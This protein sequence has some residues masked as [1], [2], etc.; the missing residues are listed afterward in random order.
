MKKTLLA[1]V[2]AAF[3]VSCTNTETDEPAAPAAAPDPQT[4]PYGVPGGNLP[5]YDPN[6]A[7]YQPIEPINPGAAPGIPPVNPIPQIAPVTPVAPVA[8]AS[9]HVVA[10][11][12]SL[13]GLAKKH[14]TTVEALQQANALTGTQINVGQSLNIP[15]AQ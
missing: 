5:N 3:L 2:P 10:A 12:D 1:I 14:N 8:A 13:W 11:G 9:T 6:S 4:N 7:A 15:A